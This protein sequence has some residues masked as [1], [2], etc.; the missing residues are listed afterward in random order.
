MALFLDTAMADYAR[1]VIK[2]KGQQD[3]L[4]KLVLDN[5]TIKDL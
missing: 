3:K 2:W 1:S 5:K 4:F